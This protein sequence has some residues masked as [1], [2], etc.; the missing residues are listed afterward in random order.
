MT[1]PKINRVAYCSLAVALTLVPAI[2]PSNQPRESGK[3]HRVG[4]LTLLLT[5]RPHI[6]GLRD[7]L[8]KAGYVEGKN[9][10]LTIP[11]GKS[12]HSL[13]PAASTY[14]SDKYDVIVGGPEALIA[15][16]IATGNSETKIAAKMTREIPIVFLP[17][18]DR[19]ALD[20]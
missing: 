20:L 2:A 16:A 3:S 11:D 1:C 10:S 4:V 12:P 8:K 7:G 9:L 15:R 6:T 18:S 17:A 5:G 14:V 19:W 13:R